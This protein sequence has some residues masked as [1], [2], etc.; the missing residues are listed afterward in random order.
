MGLGL[1]GRDLST[2]PGVSS[3]AINNR[4]ITLSDVVVDNEAAYKQSII[5]D[6]AIEFSG[7]NACANGE[8]GLNNAVK[9]HVKMS[10]ILSNRKEAGDFTEWYKNHRNEIQRCSLTAESGI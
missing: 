8:E 7:M 5:E 1:E 6:L 2:V 9:L 3:K 10:R 4:M